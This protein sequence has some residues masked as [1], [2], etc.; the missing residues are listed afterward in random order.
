[1]TSDSSLTVLD[2]TLRDGGYYN[3]WDFDHDLVA[4][5][6]K[7]IDAAR[8]D[9]VEIGFRFPPK[10]GFAGPYAYSTDSYLAQLPLPKRMTL[11]VM[12]NASDLLQ[13]SD[14]PAGAIE[15]MFDDRASSPVSLV[16][17]AAHLGEAAACGPA[18]AALRRKGYRVGFNLMQSSL[19]R[20]DDVAAAAEAVAAFEGVEVLYF[21]DSLGNM[22]GS[23][24]ASLADVLRRSWRGPLGIHTHDNIGKAL[25]NSLAAIDAGI[26]WI[27]ATVMGMGRGAGNARMEYL[28]LELARA[29]HNRFRPDAMYPLVLDQF[30]KLQRRH[31]W[32]PNLLY[33]MSAMRDIHP[34]YVQVMQADE[35]YKSDEMIMALE[36]LGAAGGASYSEDRLNRA[37]TGG[38]GAK[39]KWSASGFAEGRDVLILAPGPG[40]LRHASGLRDFV[41]KRKPLVLC[42]NAKGILPPE[43]VD[44]FVTSNV[45]RFAIESDLYR[46]Q[47]RPLVVPAGLV[48]EG[49]ASL[50]KGIDIR[51]YGLELGDGF[52]VG[53]NGCILPRAL[54]AAYALAFAN[55]AGAKRIFLA[56]FDGFQATDHR[57][58]VMMEVLGAYAG[59]KLAP[60]EALTPTNYPVQQ[61]SVYAPR[62]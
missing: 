25:S 36:H 56:G 28:L 2:C 43:M 20:I 27:D 30:T 16:R 18:V 5:Y 12:C 17:I 39:G 46:A 35:R 44:A 6:L 29:G 8:V 40:A 57:Q 11:G 47:N 13:A 51:D 32:G 62:P 22:A 10:S 54:P 53:S 4:A 19:K 55:A 31:S 23:D 3:D 9:I 21:A 1:M 61:S 15:T 34:T 33:Y 50:L 26:S 59:A 58:S 49:G 42:L 14:G 24:V 48:G 38:G 45:S 37:L 52:S 60:L 7:A 41:A